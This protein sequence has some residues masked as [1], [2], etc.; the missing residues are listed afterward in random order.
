MA[1][2]LLIDPDERLAAQ[3]TEFLGS[4]QNKVTACR[5]VS[6][7]NTEFRANTASYD[8]IALNMS[9]NR[10]DDWKALEQVRELVQVTDA[11]PRIVC[12]STTYWGPQMQLAVE[13]KGGRL[14]YF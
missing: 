5:G 4:R 10:Q 9:R 7:A 2:I 6:E 13:R 14:V 3:L 8:V 1:N 11:A 12:F